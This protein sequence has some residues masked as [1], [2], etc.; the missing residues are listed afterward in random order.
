MF[1]TVSNNTLYVKNMVDINLVQNKNPITREDFANVEEMIEWLKIDF[2]SS[3]GIDDF[4][5]LTIEIV[6][7]NGEVLD[8]GLVEQP[9]IIRITA[10]GL[11]GKH[12]VAIFNETGEKVLEEVFVFV[13]GV[14]Q[15]EIVF[16][17]IGEYIF[18]FYDTVYVEDKAVMF[19][20][21]KSEVTITIR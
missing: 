8:F 5:P 6:D 1:Y 19:L 2:K 18:C 13:D 3:Y 10:N 16:N 4:H 9:T 15:E 21:E 20:N 12:K 14:A 11:E 17:Q 7:E